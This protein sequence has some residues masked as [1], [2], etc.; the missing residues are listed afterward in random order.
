MKLV[1]G[2]SIFLD[3]LNLFGINY[4]KDRF[5][6]LLITMLLFEVLVLVKNVN[7][8]YQNVT[9]LCCLINI[10]QLLELQ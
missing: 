3:K 5:L 8:I 10:M 1:N 7:L 6:L 4:K 2:P 9:A